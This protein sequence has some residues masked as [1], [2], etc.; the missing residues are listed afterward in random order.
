M[1]N[2]RD[3]VSAYREC[4]R[5]NPDVLRGLPKN[6]RDRYRNADFPTA[7]L[8]LLRHPELLRALADDASAGRIPPDALIKNPQ[9]ALEMARDPS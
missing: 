3:Y 6:T 9:N 5:Q 2:L 7:V 4:I 1:G 8:W